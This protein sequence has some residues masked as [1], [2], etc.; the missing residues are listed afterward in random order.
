MKEL[1]LLVWQTGHVICDTVVKAV[2]QAKGIIAN[3]YN[4]NWVC[5]DKMTSPLVT[6]RFKFTT[7]I[8]SVSYGILR[9]AALVYKTGGDWFEIDKGYWNAQ[10]FN[11]NYRIS[12]KGTQPRYSPDIPHKDHN[13]TLEPWIEH[14]GH[15]LVCPP[16]EAVAEFFG[17]NVESWVKENTPATL[18]YRIRHKY[19]T[20]PIEWNSVMSV[21]TFNS[22][23]GWQALQRGIPCISDTEHSI[24]GSYYKYHCAKKH[25]E[26]NTHSVRHIHRE[27]LFRC[28]SAHQFTL[29][30]IREGRA[31]EL[32]EYYL[33]E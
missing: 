18:P 15:V 3:V 14:G 28:M 1:K 7:P 17:I 27:Q 25:L 13:V 19:V 31:N 24:V 10:H 21:I 2:E 12:Y 11:G 5:M 32:F 23:V 6:K 8:P 16:T 26:Y 4:P 9:N 29:Q 33:N 30:E 20:E 22:S